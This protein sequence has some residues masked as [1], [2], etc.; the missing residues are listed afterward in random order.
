MKRV[1]S[2]PM[3]CFNFTF[4]PTKFI[5]ISPCR[6]WYS[7]TTAS[8]DVLTL[9]N[10]SAF[11]WRHLEN[12]TIFNCSLSFISQFSKE[13]NQQ[14]STQGLRSHYSQSHR[15]QSQRVFD[16]IVTGC[17]D[18]ASVVLTV[19]TRLKNDSLKCYSSVP[20]TGNKHW[21]ERVSN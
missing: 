5:V 20:S 17:A 3:F 2:S 9:Q 8:V 13:W 4:V 1:Y 6:L 15:M 21:E 11:S 12:N 18:T 19:Y 14:K 7:N 10:Q 16:L